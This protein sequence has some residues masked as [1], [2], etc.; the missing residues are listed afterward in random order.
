MISSN[1]YIA[2]GISCQEAHYRRL[3]CK[4][5]KFGEGV[6]PDMVDWELNQRKLSKEQPDD[7]RR[8]AQTQAVRG[9][10]EGR[11]V[12]YGGHSLGGAEISC[13]SEGTSKSFRPFGPYLHLIELTAAWTEVPSAGRRYRMVDARSP[14]P[15]MS[16][17]VRR[18]NPD[19]S[20]FVQ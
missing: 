20:S 7:D 9:E 11:P 1:L 14:C 19:R 18:S 2:Q 12:R 4:P 6:Q 8:R 16:W 15:I 10:L 3:L 5:T 13:R 17:A